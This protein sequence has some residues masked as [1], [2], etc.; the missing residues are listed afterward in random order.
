V[1]QSIMPGKNGNQN[2]IELP[3]LPKAYLCPITQ[4]LM[5]DPVLTTVGH[6]YER[7]AILSW[8]KDSPIDPNS[9]LALDSLELTPNLVLK[10]LIQD[11]IEPYPQL[12]IQVLQAHY[13][14]KY[15]E[16]DYVNALHLINEVLTM[17]SNNVEALANRVLLLSCLL[18]QEGNDLSQENIVEE[19]NKALNINANL[20]TNTI[21]LHV[22]AK[23]LSATECYKEALQDYDAIVNLDSNFQNNLQFFMSRAKVA[24]G[25]AEQT[26]DKAELSQAIQNYNRC[27]ELHPNETEKITIFLELSNAFLFQGE[28]DES[29][30]VIL[31]CQSFTLD[32]EIAFEMLSNI[33]FIFENYEAHQNISTTAYKATLALFDKWSDR[34]PEEEEY[35]MK[36]HG[37]FYK[38]RGLLYLLNGHYR[39]ALNDLNKEDEKNKSSEYTIRLRGLVYLKMGNLK[40]AQDYY[41]QLKKL[42]SKT[43]IELGFIYT[44]FKDFTKALE[45]YAE[46][47]KLDNN[48]EKKDYFLYDRGRA[49]L[50]IKDW[51]AA[52]NDYYAAKKLNVNFKN[53]IH[54]SSEM[55]IILGEL[56]NE[57]RAREKILIEEVN[58]VQ[59]LQQQV[60]S[61]V[62]AQKAMQQEF[63]TQHENFVAVQQEMQQQFNTMF[64]SLSSLQS[65]NYSPETIQQQLNT[66]LTSQSSNNSPVLFSNLANFASSVTQENNTRQI[67]IE[68]LDQFSSSSS[69][70]ASTPTTPTTPTTKVTHS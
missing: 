66:M 58:K 35:L 30:F 65:S 24:L 41:L 42:S 37:S 3:K 29:L 18:S 49:F 45:Y 12:K 67:S 9:G 34:F 39:E 60:E 4:E 57:S 11:F 55:N 28:Y 68:A 17:E 59:Q 15:K 10:N 2:D 25:V 70:A 38:A 47:I 31:K 23:A 16:H 8:F 69:S 1:E 7:N 27:L 61:F 32:K 48:L 20:L 43:F 33:I 36:K 50:G 46:A 62:A 44:E 21:F 51:E 6:T 63:K 13:K 54:F 53:N 19:C 64:T 56:L 22:R 52:H 5:F 40:K 14:A 26:R